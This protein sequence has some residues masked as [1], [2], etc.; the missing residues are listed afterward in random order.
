M[1][2]GTS[3]SGKQTEKQPVAPTHPETLSADAPPGGVTAK[4]LTMV[5]PDGQ[6]D[7]DLKPDAFSQLDEAAH[8]PEEPAMPDGQLGTSSPPDVP[9]PPDIAAHDPPVTRMR[10]R[11]KRPRLHAPVATADELISEV[12]KLRQKMYVAVDQESWVEADL[13]RTRIKSCKARLRDAHC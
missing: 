4:T 10:Q 5:D 9:A 11:T 7:A 13:C 8:D 1:G 3:Q 2:L 12:A 6:A